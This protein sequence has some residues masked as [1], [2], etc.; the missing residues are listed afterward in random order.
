[1]PMEYESEAELLAEV[2]EVFVKY[3]DTALDYNYDIC[4]AWAMAT[5]RTEAFNSV[6]YLEAS[7]PPGS[8][9]SRVLETLQALSY[10]GIHTSHLTFS[11]IFRA[12]DKDHVTLLVD[13]AEK[14]GSAKG[15]EDMLSVLDGGYR[16]GT[17][18]LLYDEKTNDYRSFEVFGFKA[19]ASTK[20]LERSLEDRYIPFLMQRNKRELPTW[21]KPYDKEFV[22]LRGKLLSYRFKLT[23]EENEDNEENEHKCMLQLEKQTKDSR[24]RELFYPLVYA[25][26]SSLSSESSLS[27]LPISQTISYLDESRKEADY[28]RVFSEILQAID[29]C[30]DLGLV[31]N[32]RI[33][34]QAITNEFNSN[35][36][37]K[38]RVSPATVGGYLR[39]LGFEKQHTSE[40][41]AIIYSEG[42]MKQLRMRFIKIIETYA[43]KTGSPISS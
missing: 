25:N 32:G 16:R 22:E 33:L 18:K 6:S 2:R 21:V 27:S 19:I 7:G 10:R 12:I 42:L 15:T 17:T 31:L 5:W 8:G 41:N 36:D 40:G 26:K 35:R 14:L 28:T 39:S 34:I 3:V 1:M 38:F 30:I 20:P 11:S 37:E 9:K 24:L 23:A 29:S 43:V 4:A 13:Q